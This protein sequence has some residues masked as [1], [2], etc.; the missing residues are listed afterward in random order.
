MGLQY[1]LAA[2]TLVG[3]AA[4]SVTYFDGY[5]QAY[6]A[7]RVVNTAEATGAIGYIDRPKGYQ[8]TKILKIGDA[9]NCLDF[10]VLKCHMLAQTLNPDR[11]SIWAYRRWDGVGHAVCVIDGKYAIDWKPAPLNFTP[12]AMG[13]AKANQLREYPVTSVDWK[14][15]VQQKGN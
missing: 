4:Q 9:G 2:L 1:T 11:L 3:C 7:N 14:K 13:M 10:A 8:P 12:T 15:Q 6:I 5:D